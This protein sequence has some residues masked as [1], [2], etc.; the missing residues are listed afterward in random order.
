MSLHVTAPEGLGHEAEQQLHAT[1]ETL[2]DVIIETLKEGFETIT[3]PQYAPPILHPQWL[4]DLTPE[5]YHLMVAGLSAWK[6]Y[7]QSLLNTLDCGIVECDNEMKVLAPSIKQNIRLQ[8][9]QNQM[10]KP[11]EKVI[12]DLVLT[13]PRYIELMRRKQTLVQKRKLV[14]PHFDRYGR[15]LRVLSRALEMRR[16]E[17]EQAGGGG[18]GSR[19]GDFD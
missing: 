3:R 11:A 16:Q 15:E 14:E 4:D 5:R 2:D 10:T 12:D 13:N 9:K 18:G 17:L 1:W 8:A 6:T 19:R 7:T